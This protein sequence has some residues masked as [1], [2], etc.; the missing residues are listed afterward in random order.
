MDLAAY[1]ARALEAEQLVAAL[2][3]QVCRM[4][5]S[6]APVIVVVVPLEQRWQSGQPTIPVHTQRYASLPCAHTLPIGG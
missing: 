3:K 2:S 5:R 4:I 1:E 6:V